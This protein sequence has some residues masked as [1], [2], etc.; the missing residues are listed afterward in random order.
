MGQAL[1]FELNFFL[2]T[3]QR[4]EAIRGCKVAVYTFCFLGLSQTVVMTVLWPT[5]PKFTARSEM[6]WHAAFHGGFQ[7]IVNIDISNELLERCWDYFFW[8]KGEVHPLTATS[9]SMQLYDL[10]VWI[11]VSEIRASFSGMMFGNWQMSPKYLNRSLFDFL[12]KVMPLVPPLC[13]QVFKESLGKRCPWCA[14]EKF[15]FLGSWLDPTVDGID[16]KKHA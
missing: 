8:K 2:S 5:R 6:Q 3:C 4:A 1:L 12:F 7:H 10:A 11:K 14:S 16:F 13:T 15:S 9:T